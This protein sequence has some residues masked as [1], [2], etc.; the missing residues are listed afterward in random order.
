MRRLVANLIA[1][2]AIAGGLG[3]GT[4][5]TMMEHDSMLS[6]R[7][8][9][10]WLEWTA[11]GRTDAD[12]YA[13]AHVARRGLLPLSSAYEAR[14]LA[15]TD[16]SGAGLSSACEYS[17]VVDLA[18]S[19]FWAIAAYNSKGLLVP[20]AAE[21]YAFNSWT[22]M[23]EPDGKAVITLARDARPGNWLPIGGGSQINVVLTVASAVDGNAAATAAKAL[24]EIARQRCR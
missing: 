16:S 9:G 22:A 3:Y 2:A 24:P 23:R 19:S 8:V 14:Y 6:T 13:R 20:N 17:I 21:R 5:W 1:F 12:P 15:N 11:L 4:A 18:Q 7:S 10:P